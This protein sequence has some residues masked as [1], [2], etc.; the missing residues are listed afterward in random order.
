MFGLS[1]LP[2]I[3]E[4]FAESPPISLD[5]THAKKK[6]AKLQ[7]SVLYPS[8][9]ILAPGQPQ[10]VQVSATVQPRTGTPLSQYLL[11]LKVLKKNGSKVFS[12]SFHPTQASSVT[13]LSMGAVAPGQYDVT[14]ELQG[15]GTTVF[16]PKRIRIK[17]RSGP[18]ATATP[19]ITATPTPTRTPTATPTNDPSPTATATP[20]RTATASVTPTSSR[21]AT[22]TVT[23]T[24]T[25]TATATPTATVT[26]TQRELRPQPRRE[27]QR[28]PQR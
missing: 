4:S 27:L 20:T 18:S 6:P 10:V 2:S 1:G 15:G 26:A 13:T 24:A 12:D 21:T 23:R 8:D 25:R 16:A 28:Q 11:M 3:S 22:P 5:G 9:G 17:K 7:V 14:A 19:T